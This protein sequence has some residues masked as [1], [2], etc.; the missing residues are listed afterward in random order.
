LSNLLLLFRAEP[1]RQQAFSPA[2]T[3]ADLGL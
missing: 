3:T 1:H 2:Q